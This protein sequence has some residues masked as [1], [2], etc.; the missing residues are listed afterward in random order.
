MSR[1][2][3]GFRTSIGSLV[4]P[5]ASLYAVAA[6]GCTLRQ[7]SVYNTTTTAVS[8]KLSRL[9]TAGTAPAAVTDN[10]YNP[11]GPIALCGLHQTH[12]VG[13]TIDEEID[14]IALGAV[15]GSGVIWTFGASGL[16]IPSGVAN[17]IGIV[18]SL[19]TGQICD[20]AFH[21]DE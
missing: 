19:G 21:W 17:G 15:V 10:E 2:S 4:L 12:T 7:V 1:F 3:A 6:A 5:I 13:P 14:R 8:L 11:D 20:V 16:I 9:D 18:V